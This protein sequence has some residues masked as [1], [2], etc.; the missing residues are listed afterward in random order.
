MYISQLSASNKTDRKS[1]SVSGEKCST[2]FS[3]LGNFF[4]ST[5]RA[6]GLLD[7]TGAKRNRNDTSSEIS[8]P[9]C[10]C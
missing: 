3:D 9:H 4:S 7:K 8:A 1:T 6:D 5:S 2:R 10:L